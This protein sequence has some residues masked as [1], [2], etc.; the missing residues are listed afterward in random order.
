MIKETPTT[1]QRFAELCL[2][3]YSRANDDFSQPEARDKFFRTALAVLK[4]DKVRAPRPADT[5]SRDSAPWAA[6]LAVRDYTGLSA[7]FNAAATGAVTTCSQDRYDDD[8]DSS[9]FSW[10]ATSGRTPSRPP[11][12]PRMMDAD[13]NPLV[14][15]RS[16]G[17]YRPLKPHPNKG[18]IEKMRS[19]S[20]QGV[21]TRMNLMDESLADASSAEE[22]EPEA[23]SFMERRAK[24]SKPKL[25]PIPK[26][27]SYDKENEFIRTHIKSS[28]MLYSY[29]VQKTGG[30]VRLSAGLRKYFESNDFWE[31]AFDTLCAG[32]WCDS[33][34]NRP[35]ANIAKY[36]TK[37]IIEEYVAHEATKHSR[38][39]NKFKDAAAL[40]EWIHFNYHGEKK[41]EMSKP[42]FCAWFLNTMNDCGWRDFK[43]RP[44]NSIPMELTKQY[45]KF[46]EWSKENKDMTVGL[47]P[48]QYEHLLN[49]QRAKSA[50]KIK[51]GADGKYSWQDLQK[52]M[53]GKI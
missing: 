53:L 32:G 46:L 12:H 24:G 15:D 40:A 36:L 20:E 1:F 4:G 16:L 44:I 39:E 52:A 33:A 5:S 26:I 7:V 41:D 45:E 37:V 11:V 28:D 38:F 8:S 30:G 22:S 18:N 17:R 14:W 25:V 42:E 23:V 49:A 43:G 50:G 29:V 34:T 2:Q 6:Y 51:P 48:D 31:F 19:L 13:G 47:N 27:P 35:I 9:D 3:V 21:R 10:D